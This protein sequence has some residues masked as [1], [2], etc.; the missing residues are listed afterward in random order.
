MAKNSVT[1]MHFMNGPHVDALREQKPVVGLGK[2]ANDLVKGFDTLT[3]VIS[4]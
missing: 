3:A 1:Y 4:G 2:P